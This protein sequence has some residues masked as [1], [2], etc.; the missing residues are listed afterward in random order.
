MAQSHELRLAIVLL[1]WS[2]APTLAGEAWYRSLRSI[3]KE[4]MIAP[5]STI[6]PVD[7]TNSSMELVISTQ[8]YVNGDVSISSSAVL[9]SVAP[10]EIGGQ[11]NADDAN[12]TLTL[13]ASLQ[14]D[15]DMNLTGNTYLG[16]S[17]APGITTGPLTVAGTCSLSGTLALDAYNITNST[18]FVLA[19][20]QNMSG[21]FDN[22][23][24]SV[25][26]PDNSSAC[27]SVTSSTQQVQ[28]QLVVFFDV[29]I[30]C[31]DASE[32]KGFF[33]LPWN[34]LPVFAWLAIGGVVLL[35]LIT[36]FVA[37]GVVCYRRGSLGRRARRLSNQSF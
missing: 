12:L 8:T 30:L 9:V 19:E 24:V 23:V 35:L 4:L 22:T 20:C 6:G 34:G 14:V 37:V 18:N 5:A 21:G 32:S 7:L 16:V 28:Q 27:Y 1:L 13:T 10:I 25:H 15:G 2:S 29:S 33:Y 11:L 3:Q 31:K 36:M 17:Y 26:P